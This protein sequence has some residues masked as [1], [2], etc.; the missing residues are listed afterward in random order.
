M[1]SFTI[2]FIGITPLGNLISGFVA[3]RLGVVT[4]LTIKGLIGLVATGIFSPQ[5]QPIHRS[6]KHWVNCGN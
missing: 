1:S 5:S 6:L 2:A 3:D 4:T